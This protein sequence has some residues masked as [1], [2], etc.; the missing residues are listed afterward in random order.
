M[1]GRGSGLG[2]AVC[3]LPLLIFASIEHGFV[4]ARIGCLRATAFILLYWG[5]VSNRSFQSYFS[6]MSCY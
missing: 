5:F 3:C 2:L 4:D 1:D 6:V